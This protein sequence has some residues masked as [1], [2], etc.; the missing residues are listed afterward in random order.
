MNRMVE[1]F[2]GGLDGFHMSLPTTAQ[3]RTNCKTGADLCG[4]LFH[5]F[6]KTGLFLSFAEGKLEFSSV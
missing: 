4:S 1:G 2:E 3:S 6:R 5:F